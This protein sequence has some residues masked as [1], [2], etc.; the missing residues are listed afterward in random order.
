MTEDRILTTIANLC[1]LNRDCISRGGLSARVRAILFFYEYSRRYSAPEYAEAA[2]TH[3]DE[4]VRLLPEKC[5]TLLNAAEAGLMMDYLI[6]NGH[7]SAGDDIRS[8]FLTLCKWLPDGVFP[9]PK[10]D[11]NQGYV[12][13]GIALLLILGYVGIDRRLFSMVSR[14]I[15][16]IDK[17]YGERTEVPLS[18]TGVVLFYLAVL[19]RRNMFVD[20]IEDVERCIRKHIMRHFDQG[21]AEYDRDQ[22]RYVSGILERKTLTAPWGVAYVGKG[23]EDGLN[24]GRKSFRDDLWL[25]MLFSRPVGGEAAVSGA[26]AAVVSGVSASGGEKA[27][28]ASTSTLTSGVAADVSAV[29]ALDVDAVAE[30]LEQNLGCTEPAV[31]SKLMEIG[32]YLMGFSLGQTLTD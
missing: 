15:G 7:M 29:S 5:G 18:F 32:L 21:E 28:V 14:S 12:W 26:A 25:D 10:V 23:A 27:A 16:A 24:A 8:I 11:R 4:Y 20:R 30:Y 17:M 22:M 1:V 2:D 13:S 9:D 3:F 31:I 19:K 6:K